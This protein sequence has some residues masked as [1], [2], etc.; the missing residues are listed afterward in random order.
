MCIRDR[1]VNRMIC[2]VIQVSS[3]KVEQEN[4]SETNLDE[5]LLTLLSQIVYTCDPF[6]KKSS[7]YF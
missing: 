4:L 1:F 3:E 2:V 5:Q 6:K 7:K